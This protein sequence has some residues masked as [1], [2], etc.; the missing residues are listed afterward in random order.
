MQKLFIHENAYEYIV[1]EMVALSFEGI[2]VKSL[3]IP[4]IRLRDPVFSLQLQRHIDICPNLKRFEYEMH[5]IILNIVR[6]EY[7]T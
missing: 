5:F 4:G 2:W 6:L 1:C 7:T 3:E